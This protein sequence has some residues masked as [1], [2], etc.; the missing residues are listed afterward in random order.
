[1][2]E[3]MEFYF[4]FSLCFFLFWYSIYIFLAIYYIFQDV[5]IN[6]GKF[7]IKLSLHLTAYVEQEL[8]NFEWEI[9]SKDPLRG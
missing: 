5:L 7:S 1:M 9:C 6:Y 3:Q 2:L 8:E 4:T